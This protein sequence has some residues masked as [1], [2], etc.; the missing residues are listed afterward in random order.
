MRAES[1]HAP[2]VSL[3][4]ASLLYR[5]TLIMLHRPGCCSDVPGLDQTF[6]NICVHA[7]EEIHQLLLLHGKTFAYRNL[8]Y[9]TSADR[10]GK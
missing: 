3:L 10:Y 5:A 7:A 4:A 2:D 8:P 1:W 9:S 6:R